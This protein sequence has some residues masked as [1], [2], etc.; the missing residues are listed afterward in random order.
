M[1]ALSSAKPVKSGG[2]FYKFLPYYLN[3]LKFLKPQFIMNSIFALLSYPLFL[4]FLNGYCSAELNLL[5]MQKHTTIGQ[6]A[7]SVA[8]RAAQN[9]ARTMNSLTSM[10]AV[11]G[12]LSLVGLF[13]FTFVTTL[14]AF[15]YLYDKNAV[16]MDYSL[17][18]DHNTRFFADLAAVFTTSI[19]PHL[20]SVLIGL[21]L[22]QCVV[23]QAVAYE[24]EWVQTSELCTS[25]ASQCMFTGI[26]ACIMQIGFTMLMISVC[27]KKAEAGLYPV[28]LNIAVPVIHLLCVAIAELS[29]YGANGTVNI[30]PAVSTSPVGMI[31]VTM[32]TAVE[33]LSG[34]RYDIFDTASSVGDSVTM[35]VFQPLYGIIALLLTLAFLVGA[36]F[37]M[38]HRR[39]ERVGMPYVYKGMNV[40]IP[41]VIIL[42]IALP[43]CNVIFAAFRNNGNDDINSYSI[44]PAGWVAGLLISTFI[45]Y[46]IMELISGRAFR[47]FHITVAK[48]AGTVAVCAGISAVL[49]YSNGFGLAY[50]VPDPGSIA[51]AS[52]SLSGYDRSMNYDYGYG[53]GYSFHVGLNSD[54]ES[55]KAITEIHK[56]I[57]KDGK[58]T[59]Y[60]GTGYITFGEHGS[61]SVRYK[62]KNGGEIS[63]SY[64]IET[65]EEF[66]KYLRA[67]IIPET[68]YQKCIGNQLSPILM[69]P[70]NSEAVYVEW[71]DQEFRTPKMEIS[72]LA[73]AIRNDSRKITYELALSNK[74]VKEYE[75]RVKYRIRGTASGSQIFYD[76]NSIWVTVYSWM[77]ETLAYL[78]SCGV[79]F[80]YS[81]YNTAFVVSR[82]GIEWYSIE[83]GALL[84]LAEG[85]QPEIIQDMYGFPVDI[86]FGKAD[87]DTPGFQTLLSNACSN[88]ERQKYAL[89]L[90]MAES[91]SDLLDGNNYTMILGVSPE[92]YDLA[93]KLLEQGI[94]SQLPSDIA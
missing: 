33:Y 31:I 92:N 44:N 53:E 50:Y 71:N 11:I 23:G 37:L 85:I 86:S 39:T 89:V 8:L 5:N 62:L 20:I 43:I 64:P 32:G 49:T 3:K 57:P 45:V 6:M 87:M 40:V 47:R 60:L 61:V 82:E 94:I 81:Q 36:Y 30:L 74:G 66:E 42:T 70:D 52:I 15:R 54:P 28:L 4:G 56:M 9:T 12:V 51:E 22:L 59:D 55:I 63:R 17:P 83:G 58:P 65:A 34:S 2:L 84:G 26:F 38:K 25:I 16:D 69:D 21:I 91:Y 29:I 7:D 67:A 75:L 90:L 80:D 93:E 78:E 35:P 14:R 18:V 19:I 1:T 76:T 41:G 48:W 79:I 73:E 72:E 24:P 27:G 46:V 68:W 77:D 88:W 13:V 10:G